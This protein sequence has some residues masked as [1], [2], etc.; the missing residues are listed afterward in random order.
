MSTNQV[1]NNEEVV[2]EL[3]RDLEEKLQEGCTLNENEDKGNMTHFL[4]SFFNQLI[5]C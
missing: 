4:T 3:T 5:S 1:Q 2:E